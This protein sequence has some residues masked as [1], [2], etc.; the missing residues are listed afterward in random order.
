MIYTGQIKSKW[1][2]LF[3]FGLLGSVSFALGGA[4]S[5]YLMLTMENPVVYGI[6]GGIGGAVLGLLMKDWRKAV[7][8]SV[9]GTIGF[10]FGFSAGTFIALLW[11][12]PILDGHILSYIV[13]G[14]IGGAFL[15][16]FFWN[17]Q[18]IL[19]LSMAG[20]FGFMS[21]AYLLTD[22]NSLAKPINQYILK[23]QKPEATVNFDF[24]GINYPS[25]LRNEYSQSYS[26]ANLG[27]L[28][29]TGANSVMIV[30]TW[31]MISLSD[32]RIRRAEEI[33]LSEI[34]PELVGRLEENWNLM[35]AGDDSV[36][37][38]I[39][40]ARAQGLRV[41]LKPH[42]DPILEWRA[43]INPSDPDA[44]FRNYEGF[45]LHYAK[46][47]ED[48]GVDMLVIGTELRS[49]TLP[50]FRGQWEAII[51]HIRGTYGGKITYGANASNP[52]PNVWTD[53]SI[54]IFSGLFRRS[55][56]SELLFLLPFQHWPCRKHA[57]H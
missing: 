7:L 13:G 43:L 45:I 6:Q 15:G 47:A 23:E 32:N 46:M 2:S 21:G 12:P 49:M 26:T 48:E 30:P 50:R 37:K 5:S 28:G 53:F 19:I 3:L 10:S 39:Q 31:Y 20:V 18:K 4:I 51:S 44:W 36:R 17:W 57:W 8:L 34:P 35:T 29:A 41:A 14:A 52:A 56:L 54:Q 9:I 25:W 11:E 24:R 55:V 38:A 22:I 40:D 1:F 33:P 27:R 16:L 42:V